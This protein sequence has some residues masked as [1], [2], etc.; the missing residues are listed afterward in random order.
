MLNG[1]CA[2]LEASVDLVRI[3]TPII[4]LTQ[5]VQLA[6][7][8]ATL[9]EGVGDYARLSKVIFNHRVS[10]ID[11]SIQLLIFSTLR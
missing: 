2:S 1:C 9:E 8:N 10:N 5:R 7:A 3:V 6:S 4:R 11:S